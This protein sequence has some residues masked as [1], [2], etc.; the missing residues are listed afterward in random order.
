MNHCGDPSHRNGP[1]N[2]TQTGLGEANRTLRLPTPNGVLS[3]FIAISVHRILMISTPIS[4]FFHSFSAHWH[5]HRIEGGRAHDGLSGRELNWRLTILV[6]PNQTMP[7]VVCQS[8][9]V[10]SS[11]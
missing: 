5:G 9:R 3:A 8:A 1:K 6:Q 2:R 4:T 10:A 7:A 11:N